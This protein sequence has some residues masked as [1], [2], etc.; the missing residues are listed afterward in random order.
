M[1]QKSHRLFYLSI[2]YI[3]SQ[4]ILCYYTI[5]NSPFETAIVKTNLLL[6][7]LEVLQCKE[8]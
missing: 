7:L 2:F 5:E 6:Q 4:M 1:R 3:E 8:L